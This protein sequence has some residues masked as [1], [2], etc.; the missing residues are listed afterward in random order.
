MN[1]KKSRTMDIP[2]SLNLKKESLYRSELSNRPSA[3]TEQS[4]FTLI[5]LMV[6]MVVGLIPKLAWRQFFLASAGVPN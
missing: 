2:T 1:L 4:G 5:E 3:S 6:A